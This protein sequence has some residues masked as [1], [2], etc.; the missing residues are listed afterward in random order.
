[1]SSPHPVNA[2]LLLL[3][4]LHAACDVVAMVFLSAICTP[5]AAA[6]WDSRR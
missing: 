2:G 6:S 3:D 5:W 4:F 1:M